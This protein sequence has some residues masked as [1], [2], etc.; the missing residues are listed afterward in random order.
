MQDTKPCVDEKFCEPVA[1]NSQEEASP[2]E[3]CPEEVGIDLASYRM[4][5]RRPATPEPFLE[6]EP[7]TSFWTWLLLEAVLLLS[8]IG[9][10]I[11][12]R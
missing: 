12:F 4:P 1:P 7:Q 11:L 2:E 10:A 8:C 3:V 6:L 5:L 9:F